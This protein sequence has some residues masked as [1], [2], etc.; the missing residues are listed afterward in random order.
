[1]KDATSRTR[2]IV[3]CAVV[4]LLLLGAPGIVSAGQLTGDTSPKLSDTALVTELQKGGH[5]I[6]FRHGTT[7]EQGEKDVAGADLD[8]CSRQRPLSDA[9]RAQTKG[10]GAAF[11]AL[12][13]PAGEVY[14]SPYCRCLDTA[15]NIFGKATKSNFLHFAVHLRSADRTSVT[16]QLLDVLATVPP[17]GT[18]TAVVSHTANLQEAV[19]I[20]P[21]PEGVA[22]VFKPRGDGTFSYV[23]VM[24]PE[25]WQ[26]EAKRSPE[27]GRASGGW[28]GQ[29]LGR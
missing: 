20:W 24:Q 9:G 2:T 25:T 28:F 22:H 17:P 29:L 1:M 7:S 11:K 6:Y 3:R 16:A 10:I 27:G 5:V 21:K 14:S 13:I 26:L 12:R 15:R 8:D 19:G 23:G 18:N 4:V